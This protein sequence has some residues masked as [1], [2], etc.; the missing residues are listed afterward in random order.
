[1]LLPAGCVSLICRTTRACSNKKALLYAVGNT[2]VC[3]TLEEARRLAYGAWALPL[4]TTPQLCVLIHVR[5]WM[6]IAP[7][8]ERKYKMVTVQGNVIHKTG[9]M[10]GGA[11]QD[12]LK[13][14]STWD[15]KEV[16]KLKD[17]KTRLF[18]AIGSHLTAAS[19]CVELTR[20]AFCQ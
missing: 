10:T 9:N 11:A 5:C 1:M 17:L 14:A 15:E 20:R 12:L 3:E 13:K 6:Y 2:L 4:C 18:K 16:S 8:N 19:E 7:G